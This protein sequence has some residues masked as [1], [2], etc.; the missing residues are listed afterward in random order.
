AQLNARRAPRPDVLVRVRPLALQLNAEAVE[1]LGDYRKAYAAYVELNG[2]EIDPASNPDD[3]P[4]IILAA[5]ARDVP[6]LPRDPN[7][8][9]VVMTGFPRS[10][11]TLLEN[12]LA[13]HPAIETFEEIPS[14]AS[15]EL[16]LDRA[17]PKA[18]TEAERVRVY[19]RG[20]DRYYD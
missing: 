3:Y 14:N 8:S 7:A 16:F 18:Q 17:L 19:L 4:R 1:K 10:G 2:V 15:M 12:A 5:A 13:A 9:H 20:R 6:E 11:T